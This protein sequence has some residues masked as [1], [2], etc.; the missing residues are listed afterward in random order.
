[1]TAIQAKGAEVVPIETCSAGI[2]LHAVL[3]QIGQRG[4]SSILVE[5]GS[6]LNS[7]FL[8]EN[9]IDRMVLFLAPRIIGGR[10]APGAFGGEG[11]VSLSDSVEL[12]DIEITPVGTDLMINGYVKQR[13]GR[14]VYRTC[15]GAGANS[16]SIPT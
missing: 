12:E 5:A 9:L 16:C 3:R 11:I 6:T 4:Y 8:S 7:A 1:L 10:L 14:D 2:D 15:R 13:E